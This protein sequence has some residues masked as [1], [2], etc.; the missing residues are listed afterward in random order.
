MTWSIDGELVRTVKA[1]EAKGGGFPQ[2]PSK[3]MFSLWAGGDP[4]MPEGTRNW[5]GGYAD[6]STPRK[7]WIDSVKIVN[8]SPADLYTYTDSSGNLQSI[9]V[10]GGTLMSNKN[11]AVVG[12]GSVAK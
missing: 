7:M 5:A 1:T 8:Y 3:V 4:S 12:N 6:Y 10:N 2:T 9:V 11:G